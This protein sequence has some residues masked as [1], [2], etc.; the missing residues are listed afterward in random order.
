[1]EPLTTAVKMNLPLERQL[2]GNFPVSIDQ[3]WRLPVP[4]KIR[5][6]VMELIAWE[7]THAGDEVINEAA[8]AE[9]ATRNDAKSRDQKDSEDQVTFFVSFTLSGHI[10][11][12]TPQGLERYQKRLEN[13]PDLDTDAETLMG[14]IEGWTYKQTMD[15]QF[16]IRLPQKLCELAGVDKGQA[17][18]VVGRRYYLE[19]WGLEEWDRHSLET[20]K[21]FPEIL[22]NLKSQ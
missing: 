22:K 18:A 13:L 4:A 2:K 12:F 15:K 14:M 10:G 1:V 3:K 7:N 20:S 19:V 11:I 16:R 8:R 17:V 6:D 9:K 5:P 21:S